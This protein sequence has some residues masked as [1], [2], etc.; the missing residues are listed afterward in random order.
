[1]SEANINA[2]NA[3]NT[4]NLFVSFIVYSIISTAILFL[5]PWIDKYIVPEIS[6]LTK[7]FLGITF[8]FIGTLVALLLKLNNDSMTTSIQDSIRNAIKPLESHFAN[9]QE[10]VEG[11]KDGCVVIIQRDIAILKSHFEV[12]GIVGTIQ[13]SVAE[14]KTDVAELKTDVGKILQ[15]LR[16][17]EGYSNPNKKR[18]K[19]GR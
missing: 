14:L 1:M 11:S 16:N 17:N 2:K 10:F 3:T 6:P 12:G 5:G 19:T 18:E 13:G 8:G 7:S 4:M 15:I 9:Q